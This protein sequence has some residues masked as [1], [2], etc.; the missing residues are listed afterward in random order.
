[1][2]GKLLGIGSLLVQELADGEKADANMFVPIDLLLPILDDS[3]RHGQ[4]AQLPTLAGPLRHGAGR[5]ARCRLDRADGPA[6][7]AGVQLGDRVI[8]VA[9]QKVGGLSNLFRK[10][11]RFGPTGTEVPLTLARGQSLLRASSRS[12]RTG[13][14]LLKKPLHH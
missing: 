7:R 3:Q 8:E 9:G 5:P 6:A 12:R 2:D 4:V 14:L 13:M 11:W 1:M 10:V